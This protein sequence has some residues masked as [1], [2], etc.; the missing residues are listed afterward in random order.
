MVFVGYRNRAVRQRP[1]QAS[2]SQDIKISKVLSHILRHSAVM[3]GSSIQ[4][5]G[6]CRVDAV[7]ACH[8]LNSL[9]TT[10]ADL[11]QIYNGS[12]SETR[13]TECSFELCRD[14]L[15]TIDDD[16]LLTKISDDNVQRSCVHE[17]FF[18]YLRSI[19]QQ[20]LLAGGVSGPDGRI[21]VHFAPAIFA[22]P[23]RID[24]AVFINPKQAIQDGLIFYRSRSNIILAR[25]TVGPE[26]ICRVCN[27][28]CRDGGNR[29]EKGAM[30]SHES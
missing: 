3:H 29:A 4:A 27:L 20:G 18:K 12:W 13:R 23:H 30:L 2:V 24:V 19:E 21:H 14:I 9:N 16:E 6:H 26:C 17:T 25:E 10:R 28:K 22:L 15:N 8:Q 11:P 7:L 1:V 5:D